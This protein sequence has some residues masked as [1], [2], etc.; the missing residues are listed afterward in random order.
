MQFFLSGLPLRARINT[1]MR[2]I[3]WPSPS[4]AHIWKTQMCGMNT[5]W[6]TLWASPTFRM[7]DV[8][9]NASLS[10]FSPIFNYFSFVFFSESTEMW[11]DVSLRYSVLMQ[12][13]HLLQ[14]LGQRCLPVGLN[15]R[16]GQSEA[17]WMKWETNEECTVGG[18]ISTLML[19]CNCTDLN[20][21]AVRTVWMVNGI[22]HCL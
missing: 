16:R 19:T 22:L 1:A 14:Y 2:R 7:T 6:K 17:A 18:E 13:Q 15:W 8:I 20:E 11:T 4:A 10:A 3:F 21:N 5:A 12:P 9:A